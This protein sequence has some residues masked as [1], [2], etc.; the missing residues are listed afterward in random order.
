M[1]PFPRV[2]SICVMRALELVQ[3]APAPVWYRTIISFPLLS[4]MSVGYI[5]PESASPGAEVQPKFH[6]VPLVNQRRLML[7]SKYDRRS[8]PW[9]SKH[10]LS[11]D[12][13]DTLL[14]V[15]SVNR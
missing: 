11:F 2:S 12:P 8:I 14:P 7:A 9:N 6:Q 1:P 5:T 3:L 13:A 15:E 10:Y 4:C